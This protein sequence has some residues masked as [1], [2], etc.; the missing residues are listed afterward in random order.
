MAR[1]NSARVAAVGAYQGL[2]DL[3]IWGAGAAGSFGREGD[4][5]G[6]FGTVRYLEARTLGGLVVR[7]ASLAGTAEWHWG[8]GWRAGVGGGFAVFSIV[9]ATTGQALLSLGPVHVGLFGYDFGNKPNVYVLGTFEVQLQGLGLWSSSTNNGYGGGL[10]I[11][12][13]LQVGARF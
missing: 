1:E 7:E 12:P 3:S 5:A 4:R 6:G 9:R 2:F 8:H 10:V 13:T 11:G